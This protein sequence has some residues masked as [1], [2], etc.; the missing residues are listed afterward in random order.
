MSYVYNCRSLLGVSVIP[1]YFDLSVAP[2]EQKK[3]AATQPLT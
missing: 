3:I 1:N 2:H